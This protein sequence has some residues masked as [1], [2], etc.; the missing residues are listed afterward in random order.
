M[1]VTLC[2]SARFERWFHAWNKAL[3]LAGHA[4]FGLCV[5]PSQM[6]GKREWYTPRQKDMLDQVHTAKIKASDAVIVLNVFAY[7]G[8]STLNEL[9]VARWSGKKV[10]VLES[11]GKGCGITNA[12][13]TV[14]REAA[15]AHGVA[16]FRSPVDMTGYPYAY[17]LLGPAGHERRSIV[18]ELAKLRP[19]WTAEEAERD[20]RFFGPDWRG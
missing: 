12:H 2:G 17:D 3:G 11:W 18:D 1:I 20:G 14:Y 5:Y 10:Y 13:A 16:D 19:G 8:E 6:E 15:Q 7:V 4:A 9:D